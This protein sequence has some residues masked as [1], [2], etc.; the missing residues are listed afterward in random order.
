MG[1]KTSKIL[2]LNGN[3]ILPLDGSVQIAVTC[4][5]WGGLI[6]VYR[7]Q[8]TREELEEGRGWNRIIERVGLTQS[9][10]KTL[11]NMAEEAAEGLIVAIRRLEVVVG[12]GLD[13]YSIPEEGMMKALMVFIDKKAKAKPQASKPS[14]GLTLIDT[15]MTIIVRGADEERVRNAIYGLLNDADFGPHFKRLHYS[16]VTVARDIRIADYTRAENPN[17]DTKTWQ[18]ANSMGGHPKRED[19]VAGISTPKL[20]EFMHTYVVDYAPVYRGV[21]DSENADE[22]LRA[23]EEQMKKGTEDKYAELSLYDRNRGLIRDGDAEYREFVVFLAQKFVSYAP[24]NKL[25]EY[26]K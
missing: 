16:P 19:V 17:Q 26:A 12:D 10:N 8:G 1:G 11:D 25:V 15:R 22:M 5:V 6:R 20:V 13:K 2:L 4:D 9:Q 23:F 7:F 14:D 3:E 18:L 21:R 24:L